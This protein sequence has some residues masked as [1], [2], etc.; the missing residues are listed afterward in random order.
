MEVISAIPDSNMPRVLGFVSM[1]AAVAGPAFA[2]RSSRSTSPFSPDFT[3]T[4]FRPA[5][6]LL[7]GLVPWAESGIRTST[8]PSWP[9]S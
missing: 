8:L 4:V 1:R 3:L 5:S 2:L 6:V 7:A 9:L